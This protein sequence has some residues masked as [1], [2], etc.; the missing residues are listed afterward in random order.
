MLFT[1]HGNCSTKKKKTPW[2]FI[3]ILHFKTSPC[4]LQRERWNIILLLCSTNRGPGNRTWLSISMFP[5]G[6]RYIRRNCLLMPQKSPSQFF[7][8]SRNN[9][10]SVW[11]VFKSSWK[12]HK[13]TLRWDHL[14]RRMNTELFKPA[15]MDKK[16]V[17]APY[18]NDMGPLKCS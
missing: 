9:A 2:L 7:Q 3:F 13:R 12:A 5:T 14:L 17:K 15:W 16:P 8:G 6:Y 1:L 4:V 18:F 11:D 10:G